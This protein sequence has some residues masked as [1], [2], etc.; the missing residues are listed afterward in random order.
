[1][2]TSASLAGSSL[3]PTGIGKGG[4]KE[5]VEAE[6]AQ[7]CAEDAGCVGYYYSIGVWV[8]NYYKPR[9]GQSTGQCMWMYKDSVSCSASCAKNPFQSDGHAAYGGTWAAQC[10]HFCNKA[11]KASGCTGS[12]DQCDRDKCGTKVGTE[13][14]GKRY[15]VYM[16]KPGE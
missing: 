9:V 3:K 4:T 14:Q 12:I 7:G 10:D 6:C 2:L 11:F 5:S 13:Y 8:V 16:K 1:M 15:P